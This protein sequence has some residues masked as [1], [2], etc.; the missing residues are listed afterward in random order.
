MIF[1]IKRYILGYVTGGLPRIDITCDRAH[2]RV[3]I[4]IDLGPERNPRRLLKQF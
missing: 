1:Q 2:V 3:Q 4:S